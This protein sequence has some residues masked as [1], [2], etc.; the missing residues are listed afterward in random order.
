MMKYK[1]NSFISIIGLTIGMTVCFFLCL[2]VQ[3]E[4]TYD[5]F[6]E[7]SDRI[8]RSLWEAKYGDN[9]WRIPLVP[10]PLAGMMES[11]FPEVE[12]ATQ[13]FDGRFTLKKGEEFVR[14]ERVLF[15]DEQF[16]DIFTV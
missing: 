14:E 2:W 13:V 6:H 10:M 1:G 8:Y 5:Q 4:L 7:K 9:S 3:D 11:E 12:S 16:F 15:V